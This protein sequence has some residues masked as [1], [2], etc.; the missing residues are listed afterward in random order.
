MRYAYVNFLPVNIL[1][2]EKVTGWLDI[3]TDQLGPILSFKSRSKFARRV[4]SRCPRIKR[5]G[6]SQSWPRTALID[7]AL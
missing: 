2:Q 7:I 4:I 3:I 5:V 1:A 6:A